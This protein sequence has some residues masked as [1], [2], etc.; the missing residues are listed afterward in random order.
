MQTSYKL[1]W[2]RCL[3]THDFG[4]VANA[5]IKSELFSLILQT[6]LGKYLLKLVNIF[7]HGYTEFSINK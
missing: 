6:F 1:L 2:K 7:G 4:D 3:N 5:P